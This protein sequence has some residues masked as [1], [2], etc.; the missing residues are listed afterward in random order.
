MKELEALPV[1]VGAAGAA[2][3]EAGRCV[4]MIDPDASIWRELS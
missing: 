2:V 4:E 3:M 1:H